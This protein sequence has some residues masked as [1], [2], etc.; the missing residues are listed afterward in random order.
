MA[1]PPSANMREYTPLMSTAPED[2]TDEGIE[3]Q[4]HM[5]EDPTRY[6]RLFSALVALVAI[7]AAA[8]FHPI[9]NRLRHARYEQNSVVVSVYGRLVPFRYLS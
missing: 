6:P 7:C 9:I 2:S 1:G 4:E 3:S 5:K 8:A